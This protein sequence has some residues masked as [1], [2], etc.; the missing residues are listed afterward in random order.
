MLKTVDLDKAIFYMLLFFAFTSSIS[1]AGGNIA[2]IL[3]SI[4]GVVR[5]CISPIKPNWDRG[6]ILAIIIFL[7][8]VLLSSIFAHDSLISLN[9]LWTY[10]YRFFPFFLA[11]I[12]IRD[13]Q[14]VRTIVALMLISILIADIYAITQGIMGN[15]RASAFSSHPMAFAGYLIQMIP[16]MLVLGVEDSSISNRTKTF[17]LIVVLFS[18]AALILNGTRGAWIAIVIV[19]LIFGFMSKNNRKV[20]IVLLTS[21]AVFLAVAINNP[22]I[23]NR[24]VTIADMQYQ[25]NSERLLLWSSAWHMFKDHPLTGVGA[26]NFAEQYHST[27]ISPNA[28]ERNLGHAHNNFLQ[29]LAETGIIGFV[30]FAYLFGYILVTSYQRYMLGSKWAFA[31]FLVTI[32]LLVQGLT[33]FNFGNSGV[34]KMYWFI[35]GLLLIRKIE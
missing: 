9:R 14:Q 31:V 28:K 3:A 24:A 6:I 27:Y 26:E 33:E 13:K 29:I 23:Y 12:F 18:F 17:T 21:L 16:L 20:F 2:I 19:L 4:L 30:S 5:Y 25:S 8:S 15:Y 22:A 32:S 35:L 34:I 7:F 10:F 11:I 1:I